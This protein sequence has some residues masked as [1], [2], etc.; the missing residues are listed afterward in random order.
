[1]TSS[2]ELFYSETVLT[3][4]IR[5]VFYILYIYHSNNMPTLKWQEIEQSIVIH[6]LTIK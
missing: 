2:E 4:L 3:F 6:L 5:L 1:M